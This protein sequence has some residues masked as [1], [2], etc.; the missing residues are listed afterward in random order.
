MSSADL[1]RWGGLSAILAG[2]AFVVDGLLVLASAEAIWTNSVFTFAFLFVLMGMVGFHT[3]QGDSYGRIGRAGFYTSVVGI[4]VRILALV[5]FLL[6][7]AALEDIHEIM[8]IVILVGFVLFGA[9]T[10]QARVLPRWCGVGFIV[11]L[12]M[13][14][15][16]GRAWGAIVFGVLWLALGYVLFLQREAVAEPHSPAS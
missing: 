12:P 16:L 4:V 6:G 2:V 9:A 5:G 15:V 3:L 10:M 8:S 1:V 11:S 14:I 13:A 7:S